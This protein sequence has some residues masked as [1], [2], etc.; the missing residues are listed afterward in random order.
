VNSRV[1]GITIRAFNLE[2]LTEAVIT[3]NINGVLQSPN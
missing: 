2:E 1:A 3:T